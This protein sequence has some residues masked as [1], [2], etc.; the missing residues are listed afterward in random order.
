[1]IPKRR[2]KAL[3]FGAAILLFASVNARA[4]WQTTWKETVT[5]AEKEGEVTLYGQARYG[6]RDALVEFA[7]V[8]PKIRLNFVGGQGSDLAKK[9]TAEKRAGKNLVDV[10]VGG[11]GTQ[12]LVYYTGGFLEP[13]S[14]AF[15]LPEVADPSLWW[16]KKHLYADPEN[17]NVFMFQGDVADR[18]GAYN[19]KLVK[20]DEI[21]SWWDILDPKWKGRIIMSDP[22]W[23]GNI[24]SWRY[25]YYSPELGPKFIKRLLGEMAITF[26]SDERQMIDWVAAGK[27]AIYLMAKDENI[28][29]AIK[30]GLPLK[31]LN[32]QKEAGSLTTGSGHISFFK[33]APHP[34]GAKV[35]I[36]WLLSR[37]GQM[38]WQKYSGDNSL[39]MDIPKDGLP[40]GQAQVPKE[41][42]Q[43]LMTSLPQYE[44]VKPLRKLVDEALKAK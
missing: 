44:D 10:A 26:S 36:N 24:G 33:S 18:M 5:A 1:V 6:V 16:G 38:A 9:V 41:G 23:A 8:Y 43:Y 31:S 35:Y 14:S 19:T 20:A 2:S 25:L 34:H 39:R 40:L 4:D 7:K 29:L 21:R 17:R 22:K 28:D 30:Q 32:A 15:V 27:Y 11:G 12:V 37:E 42:R 3:G 13:T